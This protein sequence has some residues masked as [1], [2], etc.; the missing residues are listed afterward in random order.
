MISFVRRCIS[1]CSLEHKVCPQIQ[2]YLLSLSKYLKRVVSQKCGKNN[3]LYVAYIIGLNSL[4]LD[5]LQT[6]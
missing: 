5:K 4:L 3:R 2:K 1:I 6:I